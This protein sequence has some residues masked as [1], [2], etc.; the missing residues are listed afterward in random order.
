MERYRPSLSEIKDSGSYEERSRCVLSITNFWN[1]V[2]KCNASQIVVDLTEPIIDIQC[3]KSTY[4]NCVG[5]MIHYYFSSEY[6]C[7]IPISQEDYANRDKPFKEND[8]E[9]Y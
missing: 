4:D 2:R 7:Y 3:L 5:N 6:K 9:N 8:D 1:I